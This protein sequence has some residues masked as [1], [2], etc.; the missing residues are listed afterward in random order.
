M[1]IHTLPPF[2]WNAWN[3]EFIF[4]P[5][6]NVCCITYQAWWKKSCLWDC[7][8]LRQPCPLLYEAPDKCKSETCMKFRA[9]RYERN[10]TIQ[11][12]NVQ[13]AEKLIFFVFVKRSDLP[14]YSK[15]HSAVL[16]L[17]SENLCA[18]HRNHHLLDRK[19]YWS[20]CSHFTC[21][22]KLPRYSFS[23]SSNSITATYFLTM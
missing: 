18:C 19:A 6:A 2:L 7:L 8:R 4:L 10:K 5:R 3:N 12:K 23:I 14:T 16:W 13:Q 9:R 21:L 11:N 20:T 15:W 1:E 22:S 17:G